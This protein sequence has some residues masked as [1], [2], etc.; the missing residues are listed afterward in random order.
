[1]Q[2]YTQY[3][4]QIHG[5]NTSS[6]PTATMVKTDFDAGTSQLTG[7]IY[8]NALN[9]LDTP[10][11]GQSD[12]AAFKVAALA[13]INARFIESYADRATLSVLDF[14]IAVD[15]LNVVASALSCHILFNPNEEGNT[16]F[17]NA[18]GLVFTG[19]LYVIAQALGGTN[20]STSSITPATT[21]LAQQGRQPLQIG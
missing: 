6:I 13:A 15:G 17:Q 12:L 19:G 9:E 4:S 1:M 8:G 20:T 3:E 16:Q 21:L 7:F 2:T 18:F 11:D 10:V 5:V 14:T